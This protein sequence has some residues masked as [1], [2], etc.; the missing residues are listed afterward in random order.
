MTL[1]FIKLSIN[2]NSLIVVYKSGIHV[3]H[4]DT[5]TAVLLQYIKAKC[6]N[7]DHNNNNNNYGISIA[8]MCTV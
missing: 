2:F 3:K 5:H 8:I 4:M 7:E 1:S 6:I